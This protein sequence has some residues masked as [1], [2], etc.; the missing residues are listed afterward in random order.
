MKATLYD[1]L[2]AAGAMPR[3]RGF[4]AGI[5]GRDIRTAQLTDALKEAIQNEDHAAPA[6]IGL[7]L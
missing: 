7:C 2:A 3:V 1:R 4:I 6:W 5:G